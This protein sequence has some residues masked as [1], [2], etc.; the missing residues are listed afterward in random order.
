M[1]NYSSC[2]HCWS[3]ELYHFR[4]EILDHLFCMALD[5]EPRVALFWV[6]VMRKVNYVAVGD[7]SCI[8]RLGF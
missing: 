7:P 6:N 5:H 1:G 2:Y 3:D 8:A 4:F